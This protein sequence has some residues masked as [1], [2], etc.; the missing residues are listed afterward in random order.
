M[1]HN[2]FGSIFGESLK[3]KALTDPTP[4]IETEKDPEDPK[5]AAEVKKIAE[6]K[7]VSPAASEELEAKQPFDRTPPQYKAATTM[8]SDDP[9][10][11]S[12]QA[13]ILLT[14]NKQKLRIFNN[15]VLDLES[16]IKSAQIYGGILGQYSQLAPLDKEAL[17]GWMKIHTSAI[18][19]LSAARKLKELSKQNIEAIH[20]LDME[21]THW[22]NLKK[23][24]NSGADIKGKTIL[25]SFR[26]IDK[27][28]SSSA[29][30]DG[31]IPRITA[32]V[33]TDRIV[34]L[35]QKSGRPTTTLRGLEATDEAT[36]GLSK[37]ESK[38]S[39][40]DITIDDFPGRED[41]LQQRLDK[42][43]PSILAKKTEKTMANA[44]QYEFQANQMEDTLDSL[45][46]KYKDIQEN[47]SD[48]ITSMG[49]DPMTKRTINSLGI[50]LEAKPER[51][52]SEP[53]LL[54]ASMN[55]FKRLSNLGDIAEGKEV[56]PEIEAEKLLQ[57]ASIESAASLTELET[58]QNTLNKLKA[59]VAEIP[60]IAPIVVSVE[61]KPPAVTKS[62]KT[63]SFINKALPWVAGLYLLKRIL[64]D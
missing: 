19:K 39:Y 44:K 29:E 4:K 43:K 20:A 9:Q 10:V 40:R 18:K 50:L 58:R 35:T 53:T 47:L 13:K 34:R 42:K 11:K 56:S 2:P 1:Y 62:R 3:P 15:R 5:P 59:E 28:A 17:D 21:I 57:K 55:A 38:N 60:V 12:E 25:K 48:L 14:K 24:K 27:F 6:V 23:L 36:Q 33:D 51:F 32:G 31:P 22:E 30:E 63:M 26:P 64:E 61:L 54:Q 41:L 8:R 37:Q 7:S 49:S 16:K 52:L 46:S 45:S